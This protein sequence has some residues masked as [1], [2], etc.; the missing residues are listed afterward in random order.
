MGAHYDLEVE[1]LVHLMRSIEFAHKKAIETWMMAVAE[2][3][4]GLMERC[5]AAARERRT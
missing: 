4:L 1:K 5:L 2:T 3:A